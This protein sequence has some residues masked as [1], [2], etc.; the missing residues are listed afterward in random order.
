[1]PDV[2]NGSQEVVKFAFNPTGNP[3]LA[4]INV[5]LQ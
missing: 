4:A 3:D 2:W 5:F 1:M